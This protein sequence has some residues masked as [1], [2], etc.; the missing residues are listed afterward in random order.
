MGAA[1]GTTDGSILTSDRPDPSVAVLLAAFDFAAAN[2]VFCY[3]LIICAEEAK[4]TETPLAAFLSL[5]SYILHHAYRSQRAS[6]YAMLNILVIRIIVEDLALCKILCDSEK[7]IAVRL[8]R[9]R[10]PFLPLTGK[11]R[12]AAAA[13]LD[14]CI[15]TVNHNLRRSLDMQ[16]YIAVISSIHRLLSYLT[17]TQ[18][19]LEFHWPLLW[20]TLLS[21]LRFL[22][23]NASTVKN[24][25]QDVQFLIEP[26]LSTMALAVLSG[27]IFLPDSPSYDDLFYKLVE[28]GDWM[29]KFRE[30]YAEQLTA[31][32]ARQDAGAIGAT[33]AGS[34]QNPIDVLTQVSAHYHTLVEEEKGRGRV[35]KNPSPR[36]V[37][38]VIKQGYET[39]SLPGMEGLDRWDRFREGDERSLLKRAA[40]YA[41]DDTRRLL[42]SS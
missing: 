31:I 38:K 23:T 10:P 2:K 18:T 29:R 27:E 15:D 9:Q 11:A 4:G 5:T 16:L 21:F 24:Q 22:T 40:R 20:Q 32:A 37:S 35:G 41:V 8:C 19:R 28:A 12:P 13:I 26:L 25:S 14:I 33:T 3:N 1:L 36:E 30:A 34:G 17:F 39:L 42:Q 7:P 6:L